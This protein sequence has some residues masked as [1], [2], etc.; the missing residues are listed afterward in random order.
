MTLRNQLKNV[1]IQNSD[2]MQPYFTR[3][4]QIKEELEAVE[5]NVEETKIIMTTFNGIPISWDSFIQGICARKKLITFNKLWK[6]CTKEE[7]WLITRE[8]KMGETDDQALTVHTRRNHNKRED[9]HH[10][11]KRKPRRDLSSVIC[12][13]CDEKGHYSRDCPRNKGSSNKKSNKKIHH[14]HTTEDDEPTRKRTKEEGVDSS[15]D[16]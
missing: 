5:E 6:E 16:G 4:F 11:G 13:T 14:A 10:K 9:H 15:S 2:T 3:V 1:K 8:E 7:A 12:Y